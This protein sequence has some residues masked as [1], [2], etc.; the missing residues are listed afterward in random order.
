MCRESSEWERC[1]L[2]FR[3]FANACDTIDRHGM[4]QMLRVNKVGGKFL[5]VVKSCCIYSLACVRLGMDVSE[6]FPVNVG[7]TQGCVMS[8]LL[9]NVYM[10]GVV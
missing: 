5:K 3:G 7:L 4:C 1:I 9:F 6:W 2:S 10:G 8:P